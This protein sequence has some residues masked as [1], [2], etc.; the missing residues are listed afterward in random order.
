MEQH[1]GDMLSMIL[2]DSLQLVLTLDDYGSNQQVQTSR[3]C[4]ILIESWY[5]WPKLMIYFNKLDLDCNDGYVSLY[6]GVSGVDPVKGILKF[7]S[8]LVCGS[9]G[10]YSC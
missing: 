5:T 2:E 10:V 4:E 9:V 7:D 8:I 6:E 3:Q 1:C